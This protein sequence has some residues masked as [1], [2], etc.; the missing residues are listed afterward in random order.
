MNPIERL[1]EKLMYGR[2]KKLDNKYLTE[3]ILAYIERYSLEDFRRL[4]SKILKKKN[5]S[6]N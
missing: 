5:E 4:L 2:A 3:N 1:T 6:K